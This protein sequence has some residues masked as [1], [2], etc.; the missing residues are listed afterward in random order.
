[1][2]NKVDVMYFCNK[3]GNKS[4]VT[5][6]F[7]DGLAR[8]FKIQ[9]ECAL[10]V[11]SSNKGRNYTERQ[12]YGLFALALDKIKES[13]LKYVITE[14]PL[15]RG[16]E[17]RM[18]PGRLDFLINYTDVIYAIE[19]KIA[20]AG[21]GVDKAGGDRLLNA[22]SGKEGVVSQLSCVDMESLP[23]SEYPFKENSVKT[24]LPVLIVCYYS[25]RNGGADVGV[26]EG[27]LV[28]AHQSVYEKIKVIKDQPGDDSRQPL[29]DIVM[30]INSHSQETNDD[31]RLAIHGLGFFVGAKQFEEI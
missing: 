8:Q 3:D 9:F 1:M 2:A 7:V 22:W 21:L 5:R 27:E 28:N 23:F 20:Y 25:L 17:D 14:F 15:D 4:R 31:R 11:F 29:F 13:R 10:D 16:Y 24:K 18:N 6:G 12:A 26:D 30:A 19:L